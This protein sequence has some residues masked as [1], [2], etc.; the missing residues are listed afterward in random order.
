MICHGLKAA[1]VSTLW[2]DFAYENSFSY[3]EKLAATG[4][5]ASPHWHW[6][7]LL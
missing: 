4:F 1:E 7:P 6:K 2:V 3:C 5:L